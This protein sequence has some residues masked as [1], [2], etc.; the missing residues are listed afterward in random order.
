MLHI[1]FSLILANNYDRHGA[2]SGLSNGTLVG[3]NHVPHRERPGP[4]QL[5]FLH[6]CRRLG[7]HI[8]PRGVF[9]Y[10]HRLSRQLSDAIA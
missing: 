7:P 3:C 10:I 9:D 2:N 5:A 1:K 4:E 8:L 6:S